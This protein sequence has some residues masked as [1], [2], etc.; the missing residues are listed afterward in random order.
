MPQSTPAAKPSFSSAPKASPLESVPAASVKTQISMNPALISSPE[1]TTHQ[2]RCL[3]IAHTVRN[4]KVSIKQEI[5][6]AMRK[7]AGSLLVSSWTASDEFQGSTYKPQPLNP[8]EKYVQVLLL[9]NELAY[10]D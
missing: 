3:S 1:S 5:A 2:A 4:P 7:K 10:V 9:S 6:Q 8:W